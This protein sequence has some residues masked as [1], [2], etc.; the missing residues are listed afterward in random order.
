MADR[1][2]EVDYNCTDGFTLRVNPR[3]LH[4]LPE[5][6]RGDIRAANKE[7]LLAIR[8]FL[9]QAISRVEEDDK[10]SRRPRK[11]PVKGSE[12]EDE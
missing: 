6:A 3:G 1:F 4:L 7:I 8:S 12:G 2:I 5:P 11:V 9:D 10:A